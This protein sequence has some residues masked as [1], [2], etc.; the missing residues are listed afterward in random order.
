MQA[1]IKTVVDKLD[2]FEAAIKTG[3]DNVGAFDRV[4]DGHIQTWKSQLYETRAMADMATSHAVLALVKTEIVMDR[5][6]IDEEE[7]R[8]R[9]KDVINNTEGVPG[10]SFRPRN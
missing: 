4:L 9:A 8:K 10:L 5:L 6:K 2:A 7:F 3:V 1:D